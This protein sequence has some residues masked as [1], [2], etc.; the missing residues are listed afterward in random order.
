[1]ADALLV[2]ANDLVQWD[3]A[4]LLEEAQ[5]DDS[6]ALSMKL[7]TATQQRMPAPNPRTQMSLSVPLAGF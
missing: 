2:I 4:A 3:E 1:M 6:T 5:Q 7:N